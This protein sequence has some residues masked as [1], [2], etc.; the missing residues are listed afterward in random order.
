MNSFMN[1]QEI[2]KIGFKAVGE[3]VY[4]SR[5]ASLYGAS[6]IIIGN[7]VRI[8]DFCILSG[9]IR[10]G[11][12]V[13]IAAY[14]AIYGG[15]SGVYMEDYTTISSHSSVYAVSD[16]YSGESMTNPMIPEEFR[17]VT[18]EK[19]VLKEHAIVGSHSVILPGSVIGEG[20]S[21]GAMSLIKGVLE[22]W[23]IYAGIPC[24]RIKSRSRAAQQ[25]QK[26]F[27]LS[28]KNKEC[29]LDE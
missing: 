28:L 29:G 10:I 8:D 26:E 27:E 2:E 22:E 15:E 19:V 3:N 14:N 18:N 13:H 17:R 7:N 20:C 6:D 24:R 11:N 9:K 25:L 16:D 21:V 5:L 1:K 23:G 4:I 12:Y